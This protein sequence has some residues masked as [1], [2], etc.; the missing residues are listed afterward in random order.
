[1]ELIVSAVSRNSATRAS[2]QFFL[3][4]IRRSARHRLVVA[5]AGGV[6]A[7]LV[8]PTL[9]RWVPRLTSLPDAPPLDLL[10]LPLVAMLLLLVGFRL[11]A[12][13][14]ADLPSGWM[15]D[16]I[17]APSPALRTGLW[18]TLFVT[19]VIPVTVIVAM[20]YRFAWGDR[21]ALMHASLC[22]TVGAV[23]VEMLLWGVDAMPCSRPWR[24]EHANVRKWWPAYLALF[25]L[26]ASGLPRIERLCFEEQ[27]GFTALIIIVAT[28]GTILRISHRRRR[29]IPESDLNEPA[30]VQV[31]N[32]D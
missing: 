20:S 8:S 32:L 30:T 16:S 31:L 15:I 26:I 28:I 9:F 10:A 13:L 21:V 25:V 14:P 7:A 29:I 2:S 5:V 11:A 19:V 6:T 27:T 22:L 1:V 3:T 24:P 17:G 12:A 4:A 23:L 18:R